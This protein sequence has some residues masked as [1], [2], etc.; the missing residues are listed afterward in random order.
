MCF[1]STSKFWQHFFLAFIYASRGSRKEL[2][3]RGGGPN[4]E[5]HHGVEGPHED[6]R[7]EQ[8]RNLWAN[9]GSVCPWQGD[10]WHAHETDQAECARWNLQVVSEDQH[11][12]WIFPP[13]EKIL[14]LRCLKFPLSFCVDLCVSPWQWFVL[15]ACK[16]KTKQAPVILMSQFKLVKPKREQRLFM[17]T[18][19]PSGTKTFICE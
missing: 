13:G 6:Q 4:T 18:S 8:T 7:E 5:H 17:E 2:Q 19:T 3:A 10:T 14:T 16:L 15:R 9:T 12:W 11:H 1:K